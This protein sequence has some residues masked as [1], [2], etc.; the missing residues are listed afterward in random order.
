MTYRFKDIRSLELEITSNCN[1]ACPQCPRNYYGGETA[2]DLPLISWT[3]QDLQKILPLDL[4][5]QLEFVYFCGTYGDPMF[6]RDIVRMC[7]WLK[8]HNVNLRIGIHTNGSVGRKESYSRLAVLVDFIGFAIDGLEDTNAIYR[9]KTCWQTIMKNAGAFIDHGGQAHWDF[10]VFEHNQHQVDQA[11]ELSQQLKFATFN[12]KK[13]YRFFNKSH[14]L[15]PKVS[16]FNNKMQKIYEIKPPSLSHYQ[17][18]SIEPIKYIDKKHFMQKVQISCNNLK[19]N[20]IYIGADGYVFP[21]GWLH[22]RM[23]GIES[24]NTCDRV[25]LTEMMQHIGGEQLANCFHSSLQSIVDGAWFK[26]IQA[27]WSSDDRLERCAWICGDQMHFL[28]EQNELL[29]RDW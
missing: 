28:Q 11:R 2:E 23:Y 8:K 10:I 16:V 20:K 6:N 18:K 13:T 21:C 4:V 25:K 1:A 17:N 3:L 9:R 27:R 19:K 22:D 15:V 5:R 7:E 14:E 24:E 12:V 26:A 29:N